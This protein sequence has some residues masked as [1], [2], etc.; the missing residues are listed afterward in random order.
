MSD[1]LYVLGRVLMPWVFIV[2][3]IGKFMNVAGVAGSAGMA[4]FESMI[5]GS[6][7]PTVVGY[8]VALI[9]IVGGLM[10]LVGFKTR[11]GGW[12]LF[13]FTALTIFFAHN[14]WD[15][16]G[17]ARAANQTQAL[18]NLAIMSACLMIASIGSGRYAVDS[19]NSMARTN[20]P[21][22]R[23]AAIGQIAQRQ[24]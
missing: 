13:V 9:E 18:K 7:P 16:E 22:P 20:A 12:L 17:A 1:N 24:F 21:V 2:S 15:M 8:I 5:G 3:A 19:R 10:V 14:F 11:F 4:R 23:D 6:V